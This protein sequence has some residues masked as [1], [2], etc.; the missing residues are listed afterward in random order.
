M[1]KEAPT[2]DTQEKKNVT[3]EE[4]IETKEVETLTEPK[5]SLEEED[6]KRLLGII[7]TA[8]QKGAFSADE[9]YL[10]GLTYERVKKHVT[11]NYSS[12]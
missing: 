1:S 11:D 3:F 4:I 8:T 6:Y 2:E 9:M 7:N 12:N 5:F 10:T